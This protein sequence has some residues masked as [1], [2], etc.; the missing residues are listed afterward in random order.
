MKLTKPKRLPRLVVLSVFVVSL[1]TVTAFAGSPANDFFFDF[2]FFSE[3]QYDGPANK[4]DAGTTSGGHADVFVT[5]D[6]TVAYSVRLMSTSTSTVTNTVTLSSSSLQQN[7]VLTYKTSP[8]NR[9][10]YLFGNS[11]FGYYGEA[12]GIWYP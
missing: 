3:T 9:A 5:Q 12:N 10:Y 1:F 7:A 4:T 11:P 2:G 6:T 8:S